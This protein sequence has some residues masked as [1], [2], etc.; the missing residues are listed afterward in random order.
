MLSR[1]AGLSPKEVIGEYMTE[2]RETGDNGGS[3]VKRILIFAGTTEGR[4]LSECLAESGI[5]HTLCVATE[6]GELVLKKS[7]FAEVHRGRM[8][9]EDIREFIENGSFTAVVDATHP[10]AAAVTANIKAAV[11]DMDIPYLRLKR[12]TFSCDEY[13]KAVYFDTNEDCAKALKK[14]SGN[15]LLTVGSKELDK[16]C[17]YEDIKERLFV[18][19]LPGMESLRLCVEQ[20][21]AGKRII[22]M[23]GPFSVQMNEAVIRQYEIACIVTK[24]SGMRGGYP[25]KL[26]AA[27]NAGIPAYVVGKAREDEGCCFNE[28]CDKLEKICGQGINLNGRLSIILA[29]AGMGDKNSLTKEVKDEI[30]DADI[31]LGAERLIEPYKP[32]IEKR[33]FYLADQI[34]PY[35]KEVWEEKLCMEN[36]RAVILFSGDSGF[37]SGCRD[38]YKALTQTVQKGELRADIKILPGISSVAY[39][40]AAIGEN[41]DDAAI[42][43]MHGKKLPDLAKRIAKRRK[44]YILMSGVKDVNRLGEI[45]LKSGMNEV[46]I[47][48]GYQ[49][50]YPGQQIKK[51]TPKEC[52]E[53]KGEGLYVCFIK[54]ECINENTIHKRL[55]PGL[56]DYEF[57]RD[58]ASMHKVPMTKEEVR[59]LDICKLRLYDGAVV[60]DIGSGTGSIAVETAA[61]SDDI[62]VY[63]IERKK[64]A[65]S[66]ILQNKEK[67]GLENINVIEAD[68]PEGTDKLPT[69]THVFIG[70]SGGKLKRILQTLYDKG[71]DMRVVINA[72][73]LETISEIK[74]ILSLHCI[75]NIEITQINISRAKEAGAH[76]L[77]R[78]ENPVLIC[79]FDLEH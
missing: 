6:Y 63:A 47:T 69:A 32:R 45:L 60:Y 67:F 23:Q 62:Q 33:P 31:L 53:R 75:K 70:G 50:S 44:T 58:N 9:R 65:V 76:H 40:A 8:D 29:G 56:P 79:A 48:L 64:E 2:V 46:E 52:I 15:I 11:K 19:V 41:Y 3:R 74:E 5:Y 4:K 37:Y 68:A 66:L 7:P 28:V 72:V 13:E 20:G 30:E 55:T 51:L 21:I 25:E 35:L 10:Y 34:I 1:A 77:F 36:C 14:I 27:K 78:A 61:L 39:L 38:L 12:D 49:L 71:N 73:S 16:Y 59:A 18:R 42:L 54:N 24:Q 22:A 57:I 26:E 17:K 43:S